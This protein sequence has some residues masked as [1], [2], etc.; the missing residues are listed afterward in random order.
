MSNP[1]PRPFDGLKVLSFGAFVAGT[2]AGLH[3]A[4]LGADVVKIEAFSRPEVLR[5]P[6]FAIGPSYTEP[7]GAPQTL[8]YGTLVRNVRSLS[9]D[10]ENEAARPLFHELVKT[11][12][13]LIENFAGP[14]LAK[15]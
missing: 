10:M 6:G 4:E 8:M 13:V 2:T 3:L 14:A 1:G 15:W 12:D 11:A 5:R 9:I 7:S